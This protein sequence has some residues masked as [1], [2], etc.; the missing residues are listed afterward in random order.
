MFTAFLKNYNLKIL[1]DI[2]DME[3]DIQ[4]SLASK[5]FLPLGVAIVGVVLGAA[6]LFIAINSANRASAVEETY[7][8]GIEK[9][10]A[11]SIEMEKISRNMEALEA[12]LKD[13]REVAP[14][15]E[16]LRKETQ[17]ALN[18]LNGFITQNRE[19]I[20]KNRTA[21]TELA[22]R[23]TAPAPRPVATVTP[24]AQQS[25][26][27]ATAATPASSSDGKIHTI[28]AG[29]NFSV[30]AKKYGKSTADIE[31]ANP[32]VDS[33]RLQIGQEIKIP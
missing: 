32:G 31:K 10:A 19:L 24:P 4:E 13:V 3:E 11:I 15:V 20:A 12:N 29:E 7:R 18:A 5:P 26:S 2:L 21:L 22:S 25:S 28:K 17:S 8:N 1:N 16:T 33:R 23:Q 6:A 14:Q 30:I 9:T 27:S